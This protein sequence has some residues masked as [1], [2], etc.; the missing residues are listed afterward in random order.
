MRARWTIATLVFL[1]SVIA[2]PVLAADYDLGGK[3]V[4]FVSW[5]N[6]IGNFQEGG[7]FDGRLEEAERL[8]NCKIV[9]V[10][11][12]Y[13]ELMDIWTARLLSGDSE[14]D[15][16]QTAHR[17][18][19]QLVGRDY[20]FPVSEVLGE[21]YYG[22]LPEFHSRMAETFSFKGKKYL[23]DANYGWA[24]GELQFLWWNKTL[25]DREGLPDLYELVEAGEWT[26]DKAIEL[27]RLFTRDTDGDGTADQFAFSHFPR[28]MYL[29]NGWNFTREVDGRLVWT[30]ATPEAV[31]V[32]D[33]LSRL[34]IEGV[35][36]E[37]VIGYSTG[38]ELGNQGKTA[39]VPGS[40]FQYSRLSGAEGVEWGIV[41]EP[42]GSH[43]D[44]YHFPIGGHVF[45]TL[46][47]NCKEPEALVAL[48]NF[49]WAPD[50][51]E[52]GVQEQ[53]GA[54]A[55]DRQ[56]ARVIQ[57]ALETWDGE[58]CTTVGI[59]GDHFTR[60]VWSPVIN[61]GKTPTQALSEFSVEAQALLD[62]AMQQ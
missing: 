26:W 23:F 18:F 53:T 4:S 49:L 57:R 62:D 43:V 28:N 51:W 15:I 24:V 9:R 47:A 39:F 3:T 13:G 60:K 6:V 25:W 45:F 30:G 56:A 37:G 17:Y 19:M 27:S 52:E 5:G 16:W 34:A 38:V 58:I 35:V 59:L 33:Y 20:F 42:M 12:A 61:G 7:R 1:I 44:R 22:N 10:P 31:A 55:Q 11:A 8:F 32:F 2:A 50:F 14:Y 29:T 40:L 48:V 46:P 54:Y 21:E 36:A 41:P